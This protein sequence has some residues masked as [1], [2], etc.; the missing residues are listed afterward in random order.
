MSWNL[1]SY[2]EGFNFVIKNGSFYKDDRYYV[3]VHFMNDII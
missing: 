1:V 2:F 3:I